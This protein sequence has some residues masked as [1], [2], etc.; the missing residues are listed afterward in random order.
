MGDSR[1]AAFIPFPSLSGK[2]KLE[3][4]SVTSETLPRAVCQVALLAKF[5]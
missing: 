3:P 1:D 4:V 5:G 2:E